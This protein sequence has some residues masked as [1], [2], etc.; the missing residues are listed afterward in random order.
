MYSLNLQMYS[1]ILQIYTLTLQM[2]SLTL[3]ML[4]FTLQ[5][6]SLTLQL[7]SLTLQMFSLTLQM[8]SLTLQMYSLTLQMYSLTLQMFTLTLQLF[9]LTR[10]PLFPHHVQCSAFDRMTWFELMTAPYCA[11]WATKHPLAKFCLFFWQCETTAASYQDLCTVNLRRH[12]APSRPMLC[13]LFHP[14]HIS[15]FV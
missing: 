6:F 2:F 7:F 4:T 13:I 8:F 5:L 15:P 14:T 11:N 9:S 10:L 1:L 3:Q 12:R